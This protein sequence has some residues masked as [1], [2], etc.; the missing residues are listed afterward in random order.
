MAQ[1]IEDT[2]N[3][4]PIQPSI[5]F[6]E[7]AELK[8]ALYAYQLNEIVEI[9]EDDTTNEDIVVMAIDAAVE[10]M[11]SYLKPN[12]QSRWIDGRRRFDIA[13]IFG[14]TGAA[15]NPLILELCKSIAVWY[16]CR[17][18]NVDIIE[19]KVKE[20]YDRAIT[21]LEKV[22]G[23]G[24]YADGPALNPDL[25]VLPL[26]DTPEDVPFRFGSREKFNHE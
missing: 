5:M 23:V 17:L 11:K 6:I 24:K 21:W 16:V 14:A 15:R 12:N 2:E 13:A 4:D 9:T 22:T 1:L 20:R 18:S 3:E 19:E 7:I 10:E 26:G 8:S 25:P